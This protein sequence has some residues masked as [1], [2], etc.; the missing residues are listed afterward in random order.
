MSR[1]ISAVRTPLVTRFRRIGVSSS[2]SD[3][4]IALMGPR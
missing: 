2:G 3:Q 1:T 4:Y